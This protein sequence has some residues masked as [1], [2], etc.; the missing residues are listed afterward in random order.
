MLN[1]L[2]WKQTNIILLFL[3]LHPSIAFRTLV[4]S[5][6]YSTSSKVFLSMVVDIMII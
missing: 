1:G 5:E 3:S 4:D 2:S 6:G